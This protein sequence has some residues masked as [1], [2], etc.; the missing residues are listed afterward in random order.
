MKRS[1]LAFGMF[2]L[3]AACSAGTGIAW[4][5]IACSCV[6]PWEDLAVEL[7]L[8]RVASVNDVTAQAVQ[9]ALAGK[10]VG[11]KPDS[12]ILPDLGNS[13]ICSRDSASSYDCHWWLLESGIRRKGLRARIS[14]SSHGDVDSVQVSNVVSP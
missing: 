13:D 1:R 4:S 6:E 10:L 3:I 9:G 14:M 12:R 5:P 7:Q 8:P 2:V 11:H